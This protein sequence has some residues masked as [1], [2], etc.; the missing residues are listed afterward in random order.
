MVNLS[1]EMASTERLIEYGKLPPESIKEKL[2]ENW[3]STNTSIEVKHLNF[4]YRPDL[5]L[6]LKDVNFK[7]EPKEHIGV[8]GRTGAGKSSLTVCFYR[9]AKLDPGSE[10]IVDG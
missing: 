7:F 8:V 3:P 2:P 10:I 4:R 1:G 6:V 5:P 9:L